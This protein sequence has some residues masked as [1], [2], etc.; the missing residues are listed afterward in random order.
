MDIINILQFRKD[1]IDRL[2]NSSGSKGEK[3]AISQHEDWIERPK[4]TALKHL[5]S[6]LSKTGINIKRTSFDA[7]AI[8]VGNK[9]DFSS[10]KSIADHIKEMVFI[11]IKTTNKKS[12][13]EDFTGYFFA[14]TEGELNAAEQLGEQHQVALVNKRTG[15][16][17][18]SSIPRLLTRAKSMNWQVSVQL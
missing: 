4:G 10:P 8:P 17:V 9:V 6:E 13:K 3:L 7:I 18:M 15:N 16:I 1:H 11:E 14:F 5:I 2:S 12:V